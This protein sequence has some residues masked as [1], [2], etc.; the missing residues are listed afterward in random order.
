[1]PD[2]SSVPERKCS[3]D[4]CE[5]KLLA[6]GYC[7]LHY[8]R[9]QGGLDMDAPPKILDPSRGCAVTGCD[10]KHYARGYCSAHYQR[11]S[12][13]LPIDAPLRTYDPNR[14]CVIEGCDKEHDSRGYCRLH[15]H[16]FL[17]GYDL[18]SP[19]RDWESHPG[20]WGHW[21]VDRNG[22]VARHL[23]SGGKSFRQSQHRYV[24]EQHLGRDL[25]PHENVHHINGVRDDNRIENLELWSTSQPKGQRV[26]DKV[27]WAREIIAL[28][29]NMVDA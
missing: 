5:R 26:R 6:K 16:R 12:D 15:Y 2:M 24:M 13:G 9:A 14:G 21:K 27:A 10:R 19:I 28:Y 20:E 8:K 11:D 22:Y 17:S 23:W 7:S 25:L 4:W 3:V 29:G 18:E 1:M